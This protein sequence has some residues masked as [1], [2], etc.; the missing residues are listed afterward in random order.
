MK[1]NRQALAE[2]FATLQ[3]MIDGLSKHDDKPAIITLR[4]DG[5]DR[6]SYSTLSGQT[7]KLAQGLVR[8]GLG[9]GDTVV[10]FAGNRPEWIVACLAA[11]RAGGVAVP[12]DTQ[13]SDSALARVI[14]DSGARF[15]FTTTGELERLQTVCRT[16][17]LKAFL[18]DAEAND[19]RSWRCLLPESPVP[20]PECEPG[21]VAALFYTSGTTGSSKGV[22]LTHR[23][24]VFQLNTAIDSTLR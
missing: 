4:K 2:K 13:S 5:A 22:P 19:P 9:R 6:C 1:Q 7:A 16:T 15:V 18:L 14:R 24:I 3:S 23:N 8:I 10:L 20:L 21:E 11:I 12:L 17:E